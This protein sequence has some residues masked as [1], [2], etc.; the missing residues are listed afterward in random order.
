MTACLKPALYAG[1]VWHKRTRPKVHAFRYPAYYLLLDV[2]D[3]GA[4]KP[5][6]P[7]CLSF[8]R[9]NIFSVHERDFGP[10]DGTSLRRHVEGLLTGAAVP[11]RIMMLTMPRLFGYAFNPITVY[12]CYDADGALT[13]TIYEVH[14]TFGEAHCYVFSASAGMDAVPRHEA[15]KTFHVSPFYPVEGHYS[16]SLRQPEGQFALAIR[17]FGADGKHD[18]T[19]C[20]KAERRPLTSSALMK[21]FASI[22]LVTF[23]VTAAI[24]YE[25]LRLFLKRLKVFTKPPQSDQRREYARADIPDM[26]RG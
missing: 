8:N 15:R 26:K 1:M 14:N 16:F 13:A 17:Y 25:A 21:V 7:W 6:L 3:L 10:R 4:A 20:L 9:P 24:H 19:A 18:L 11:A 23:K 22:P 12:F 2:D 5:H